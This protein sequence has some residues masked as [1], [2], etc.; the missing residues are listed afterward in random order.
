[1]KHLLGWM[2]KMA[3]SSGWYLM[4]VVRWKFSYR[5]PLECLRLKGSGFLTAQQLSPNKEST[6]SE[7]SKK[8]R[9]KLQDSYD[10][11]SDVTQCHFCH[12]LLVKS[13]TG[14]P[15]Q[16]YKPCINYQK[17]HCKKSIDQI[18]YKQSCKNP[19]KKNISKPNSTTHLKDYTPQS[20]E[21]YS[22]DCKD[23]Q[24]LQ[25]NQFNTPHY[26]KTKEQ[27]SPDHFYRSRK[28]I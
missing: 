8:L 23:D 10:L 17:R 12:I 25:I 28:G 19:Q 15:S 20:S 13:V 6:N 2:S 21:I 1:M 16:L 9:K 22:R 4:L 24:Y 5:C 14:S 27:K 18:L 26:Q 3:N 7:C 11:A